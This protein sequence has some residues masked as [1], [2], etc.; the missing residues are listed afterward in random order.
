SQRT[1]GK[2]NDFILRPV[3]EFFLNAESIERF[4]I[5]YRE[6]FGAVLPGDP[7]YEA[8]SE[9]RR[10]NGMDHWLPLFFD[11]LDTIFDYVPDASVTMDQ[12]AIQAAAERNAQVKDFYAARRTLEESF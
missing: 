1:E 6:A 3:T 12:N 10:Y 7:L 8:V 4:R 9:G 11:S 2:R 5:G